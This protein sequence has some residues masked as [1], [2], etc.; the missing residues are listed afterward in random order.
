M[1]KVSLIAKLPLQPG[2][3]DA[4]VDA[5][6]PMMEAVNDEAGTE[7]YILNFQDDDENVVWVYEL[8]TDKDAMAVHSG[9]EAMANLFGA[10]GDLLGGA[11]E[12][13]SCTPQLAE[14]VDP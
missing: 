10:L 4:F 11:P 14:G 3:R 5:F 6:R 13:I 12:L 2:K 1:S 9:S 7:L 8:Y